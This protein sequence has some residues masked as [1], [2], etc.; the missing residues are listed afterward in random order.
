MVVVE[1]ARGGGIDV[2]DVHIVGI[3]VLEAGGVGRVAEAVFA[4]ELEGDEGGG[5]AGGVGGAD[6][7]AGGFA[8]AE[9]GGEEA[10][11]VEAELGVGA[12]VGGGV[13]RVADGEIVDEFAVEGGQAEEAE[14]AV[15]ILGA[16]TLERGEAGEAAEPGEGVGDGDAGEAQGEGGA[17]GGREGEGERPRAGR[18][19]GE[20][21]GGAVVNEHREAGR[22]GFE[23][24]GG[25]V[26]AEFAAEHEAAHAAEG[27]EVQ[28]GA[29]AQPGGVRGV[30]VEENARV[31]GEAPGV[32][33]AGGGRAVSVTHGV[34][35]GGKGA[36]RRLAK[37][38]AGG[39]GTP[40]GRR[41][42]SVAPCGRA[43]VGFCA[44]GLLC[45][46]RGA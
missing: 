39:A 40:R 36:R 7:A 29:V 28:G 10:G 11:D 33:A 14:L 26:G 20:G 37:L 12:G 44:A 2:D 16:E 5:Q 27:R 21:A 32:G 18:E 15:F 8:E 34:G 46:K 38:S 13:G 45:G 1:I 4:V 19:G 42:E 22:G 24:A 41:W 17:V 35:S 43:A 3:V 25:G 9:V 23:S 6:H 31:V 30:V